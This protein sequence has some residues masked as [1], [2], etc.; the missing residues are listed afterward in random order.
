MVF[1]KFSISCK[2]NIILNIVL[3]SVRG[4][5]LSHFLKYILVM[6]KP[7]Y[8]VVLHLLKKTTPPYSV[9]YIILN[10]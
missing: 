6:D 10:M 9:F 3:N 4:C 5:R 7:E 1:I 2:R 8:K